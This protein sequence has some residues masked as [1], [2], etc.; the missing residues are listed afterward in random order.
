MQTRIKFCGMTNQQDVQRAIEL[1]ID[2]VG[3]V[4]VSDSPRYVTLEQA[5]KIIEKVPPFIIKVGLFM[6][7][8]REYI[9]S[10][11]KNIRLDLLQFH[12]EESEDF[13]LQ[14]QCPY[15]KAVP[16]RSILSLSDYCKNYPSAVGFVL[17]SHAEGQMGG[18]GEAFEWSQIPKNHDKPM[19]LAGGLTPENVA[20]A[21]RSA[22][23]YAVDV[24][25]GIE[26]S[27]GIKDL[28]KMEHFIKEVR[29]V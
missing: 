11:L 29:S 17:D 26:A 23:P 6:N 3:F 4:F 18:S 19:I 8:E 20:E 16:M 13:C 5:Q 1:G 14:F 22:H 2:A 28:V 27:K 10:V 21:I 24:S 9:H 15:L 25:S 12:G 7:S